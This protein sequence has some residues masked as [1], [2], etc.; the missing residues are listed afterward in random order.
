MD[1]SRKRPLS[2]TDQS[3]SH[4]VHH[5]LQRDPSP[6][7]D[8]KRLKTSDS[9]HAPAKYVTSSSQAN[10]TD[11]MANQ[12]TSVENV[13]IKDESVSDR[14]STLNGRS[15]DDDVSRSSS[16]HTAG[17][18]R[19]NSQCDTSVTSSASILDGGL[20]E[21]ANMAKFFQSN[22]KCHKIKVVN[23]E[24]LNKLDV[25][26]TFLG[27]FFYQPVNC[28]FPSLVDHLNGI[29]HVRIASR[30][31]TYDNP[32]I[33][34]RSVW[35]T[36]VYTDDSDV[37][38]MIVHGGSYT[39]P[40]PL[41]PRNDSDDGRPSSISSIQRPNHDLIVT[42]RVLPKL[43]KYAGT[44]RHRIKSRHWTD[45]DGMSLRVE[46]VK[47]IPRGTAITHGRKNL[48]ARV[49]AMSL[50]RVSLTKPRQRYFQYPTPENNSVKETTLVFDV[51]GS[52]FKYSPTLLVDKDPENIQTW[53]TYRLRS[54]VILLSNDDQIVEISRI[55]QSDPLSVDRYRILTITNSSLSDTTTFPIPESTPNA[56]VLFT[57]LDWDD[58]KWIK[59]GL[60]ITSSP[61]P[62][63]SPT[64]SQNNQL[65]HHTWNVEVVEDND[66]YSPLS[67]DFRRRSS[68]FASLN[69]NAGSSGGNGRRLSTLGNSVM[70]RHN[71]G[72]GV[73]NGGSSAAMGAKDR[74]FTLSF[75]MNI[76]S[77]PTPSSYIDLAKD[78]SKGVR[79]S[80]VDF[81]GTNGEGSFLSV[82][83]L[84][85]KKRNDVSD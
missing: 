48:K 6:V 22:Q 52:Y 7:P 41:H 49:S 68:N 50:L 62:S 55:P 44:S 47:E 51:N 20:V 63:Q 72:T 38:G 8:T 23:D 30:Y 42:L 32:N 10:S 65:N 14:F 78:K 19:R 74:T 24:R 81:V 15:L 37:V 77:G 76:S 29:L 84:W 39:L 2:P 46:S 64:R 82:R 53:T 35:G 54:E 4:G 11:A 26:E 16:P 56:K 69:P 40:D 28:L 1:S 5:Y 61:L 36:D 60:F 27:T 9:D 31:L 33:K 25:P 59:K 70:D 21:A 85:W 80:S 73:T 18:S 3:N 34:K 71:F 66:I 43:L 58:L 12:S 67:P 45:H 79:K 83:K 13:H 75:G 17:S 57:N